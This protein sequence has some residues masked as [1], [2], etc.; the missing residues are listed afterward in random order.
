M[1]TWKLWCSRNAA[2]VHSEADDWRV[3]CR[4]QIRVSSCLCI[5]YPFSVCSDVMMGWI[6]VLSELLSCCTKHWRRVMLFVMCRC[7]C[8]TW[9]FSP[10][11]NTNFKS[12][13]MCKWNETE[14]F[15]VLWNII[16]CT[17]VIRINASDGTSAVRFVIRMLIGYIFT[18]LCGITSQNVTIL[19]FT[20]WAPRVLHNIGT[21]FICPDTSWSANSKQSLFPMKWGYSQHKSEPTLQPSNHGIYITPS[22]DKVGGAL[23]A[24]L[25]IYMNGNGIDMRTDDTREG[26]VE[27]DHFY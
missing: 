13:E 27:S 22:S 3:M 6:R 7:A 16:P 2:T 1:T 9:Y 26:V 20:A 17:L 11:K 18:K 5:P 25:L 10:R 24:L 14:D 23:Y 12:F 15:A 19:L 4:R 21:N 8:E